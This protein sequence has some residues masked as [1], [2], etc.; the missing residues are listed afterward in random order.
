MRR[1]AVRE[2]ERLN[3]R[4]RAI[5]AELDVLPKGDPRR[6]ALLDEV[7]DLRDELAFVLEGEFERLPFFQWMFFVIVRELAG[8]LGWLA[9]KVGAPARWLIRLF[10]SFR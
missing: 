1:E 10:D 5:A 7:E 9:A 3:T 4:L 8:T 6:M 2:I